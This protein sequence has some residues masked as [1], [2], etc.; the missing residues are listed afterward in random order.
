M[1]WQRKTKQELKKCKNKTHVSGQYLCYAMVSEVQVKKL[2]V[3]LQ[4][5]CK[6]SKANKSLLWRKS[7]YHHDSETGKGI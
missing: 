1:A 6:N 7:I 3:A 4:L 5:P 2:K